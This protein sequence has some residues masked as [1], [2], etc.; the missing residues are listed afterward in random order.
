MFLLLVLLL[1]IRFPDSFGNALDD[2]SDLQK[3]CQQYL[4]Q[5]VSYTVQDIVHFSGKPI[6]F[7]LEGSNPMPSSLTIYQHPWLE[8]LYFLEPPDFRRINEQETADAIEYARFLRSKSLGFLFIPLFNRKSVPD[9]DGVVF[10]LM[11]GKPQFNVSLK[12]AKPIPEPFSERDFIDSQVFWANQDPLHSTSPLNW[13]RAVNNAYPKALKNTEAFVGMN[14]WRSFESLA[15]AFGLFDPSTQLRPL[16][17]VRNFSKSGIEFEKISKSEVRTVLEQSI[18]LV[19]AN[20]L[21]LI[22]NHHQVLEF[23]LD[24]TLDA[25]R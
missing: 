2:D 21:V 13:F 19:Q 5:S 14:K 18:R 12:H 7:R 9:F 20:S 3:L 24:F 8:P 23:P 6:V 22:W 10:D 16:T 17:V 1:A 25:D 4:S 15:L 11:S